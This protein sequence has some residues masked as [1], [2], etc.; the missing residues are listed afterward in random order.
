MRFPPHDPTVV[1]RTLELAPF[2][3]GGRWLVLAPATGASILLEGPRL[4]LFGALAKPVPVALLHQQNPALPAAEI[5]EL[6]GELHQAGMLVVG[7]RPSPAPPEPPVPPGQ[8]ARLTLRLTEGCSPSCPRCAALEGGLRALTADEARRAVECGLEGAPGRVRLDLTGGEPLLA[9]E[10]LEAAVTRARE[11]R[12]GVAVDVRTGGG[13]LDAERAAWL[14]ALGAEA[15]L[16]LHEAPGQ[17]GLEEGPLARRAAEV[18]ERLP[19]ILATGIA[20][21]PVGVARR[22]GQAMAFFRLWMGLGYR[23]M[24]L[25]VAAPAAEAPGRDLLLEALGEDLLSVADA[26]REHEARVPVRLRI[27]PLE[28]MLARLGAGTGRPACGHPECGATV[29]GREVGLAPPPGCG[30]APSAA[31]ET[32]PRCPRCAFWRVCR[33][34]CS[35][36][37]GERE[38]D[39]RCR[40]WLRVYEGLLWRMHEDPDWTRRHQG[41]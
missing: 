15:V 36:E 5:Q 25:E 28:G 14:E 38:L 19:G 26:A 7:G 18:L 23:T 33:G 24:R 9:P 40:L 22:S 10:A 2:R 30:P 34:G 8:A 6:L 11:L 12:P 29:Q 35:R 39:A 21:A 1:A 32:H 27:Q 13:P 31:R 20:C 16:C 41:A 17:P 37:R 3:K 4:Q